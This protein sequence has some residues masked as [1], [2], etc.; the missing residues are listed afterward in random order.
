MNQL[1]RIAIPRTHAVQHIMDHI[2][3]SGFDMEGVLDAPIRVID[4]YSSGFDFEF[5]ALTKADVCTYVERGICHAGIVGTEVL[6]ELGVEVWR[7]FT[8][9]IGSYPLVLAAEQGQ[10]LTRLF[11]KPVLR[12]ATPYARFVR[13]WFVNRGMSVDVISVEENAG[14]AVSFQLADAFVDRLINPERLVARG[15][16]V[17]EVLEHTRL[18][19]IVN[20]ALGSTRRREIGRWIDRLDDSRPIDPAP[21]TIP[22]DLDDPI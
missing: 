13:D 8:F 21:I 12:I 18:K 20:N 1:V 16:R 5:V 6:R 10:S 9:N 3:R 4:P 2:T 14:M 11:E 17:V 19:L 15:F 7:P 22:F